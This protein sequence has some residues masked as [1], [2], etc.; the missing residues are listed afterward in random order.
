ASLHVAQNRLR[1]FYG[2]AKAARTAGE[3]V[4]ARAYFEKLAALGKNAD[5]ERAELR[6]AKAFLLAQR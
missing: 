2:A 3:P 1:G 5:P 4:K 6:E